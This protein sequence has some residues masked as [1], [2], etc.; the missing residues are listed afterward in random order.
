MSD[1]RSC[2]LCKFAE[3]TVLDV[4]P[5]IEC[6][7]FPPVTS[8]PFPPLTVDEGDEDVTIEVGTELIHTFPRVRESDWCGEFAAVG[9]PG[10]TA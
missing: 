10:D 6:R 2:A 1:E 7:R 8:D 5:V 9:L 4:G 3:M